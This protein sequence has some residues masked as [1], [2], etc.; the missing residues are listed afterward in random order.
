VVQSQVNAGEI[1]LQ[2]EHSDVTLLADANEAA[3]DGIAA[4]EALEYMRK[5]SN[6]EVSYSV[7]RIE[8]P[9]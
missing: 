6:G 2:R 9:E 4:Q 1:I 8:D 3:E 7:S 5:V